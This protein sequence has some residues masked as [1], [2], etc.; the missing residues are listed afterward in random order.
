MIK[1]FIGTPAF[2]PPEGCYIG[3]KEY[4]GT[5][6]DIWA[7][8][9][10]LFCLLFGKIPFSG[11]TFVEIYDNIKSEE[12]NLNYRHD[13]SKEV[14]DLIPKILEK[15]PKK[16]IT[17]EGIK[18]HP[19]LKSDK[20]SSLNS[21]QTST[22]SVS[23]SKRISQ[24][25][26]SFN[27]FGSSSSKNIFGSGTNGG[28]GNGT[29]NNSKN[30]K[31]NS[32]RDSKRKSWSFMPNINFGGSNSNFFKDETSNNHH[33]Q[34]QT[35]KQS[36]KD[37]NPSKRWSIFSFKF[38]GSQLPD[39]QVQGQSNDEIGGTEEEKQFKYFLEDLLNKMDD[40]NSNSTTKE[41]EKNEFGLNDNNGL[42]V[43]DENSKKR[44]SLYSGEQQRKNSF[45]GDE[46]IPGNNSN[47]LRNGS[48]ASSE[49]LHQIP[50]SPEPLNQ[51]VKKSGI[52]S[53]L[54]HI[55]KDE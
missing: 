9:V 15:D 30:D 20:K 12:L 23:T 34:Q 24:R 49:H 21:V 3:G 46:L 50:S 44:W 25:L 37:K 48:N 47:L 43:E 35:K 22:N 16:R 18:K 13:L 14:L 5:I 19:W 28:G 11:N 45:S 40:A 52:L 51:N 4:K 29:G 1:D 31:R 26:S 54:K 8:G 17:I 33:Q 6:G 41:N 2:A 10:T 7:I 27:P 36:K 32:K 38:S 39:Q 42:M 55:K 53:K